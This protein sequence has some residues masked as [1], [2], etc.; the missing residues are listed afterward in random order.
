M[1]VGIYMWIEK[2]N[3]KVQVQTWTVEVRRDNNVRNNT[4]T[5]RALCDSETEL[6]WGQSEEEKEKIALHSISSVSWI[7]DFQ[8]VPFLLLIWRL[9]A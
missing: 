8:A 5:N 1:R 3:E 2:G 4:T 6:D 7:M 9:V